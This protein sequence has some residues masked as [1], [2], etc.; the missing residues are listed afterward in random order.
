[1][2]ELTAGHGIHPTM[3]ATWKR[4]AID[5][6]AATFWSATETARAARDIE[7]EKLHAKTGQLAIRLS[8]EWQM[9]GALGR[10]HMREQAGAST[11][12][13]DRQ[14]RGWCLGDGV[15]LLAGKLGTDVA[16]DL[17]AAGHI[18]QHLGYVLA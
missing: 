15:A 3:I 10:Q 9:I 12:T 16:H 6:M 4:Q 2:A 14:C 11:L 13:R 8:V 18:L 17:E 5:G 7:V 1:M